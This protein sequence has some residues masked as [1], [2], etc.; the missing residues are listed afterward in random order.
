MNAE[1]LEPGMAVMHSGHTHI[2]GI[3][4]PIVHVAT[5]CGGRIAWLR[6]DTVRLA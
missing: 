3:R 4:G 6:G 2:V 5:M 1:H